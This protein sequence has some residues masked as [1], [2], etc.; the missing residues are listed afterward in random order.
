MNQ[1]ELLFFN[2]FPGLIPIY[3][4]LKTRLEATYPELRL[5]LSKTQISFY[6]R[7]MFAM[8]SLPRRLKGW[9]AEYLLVS[10]GLGYRKESPRIAQA[11][12]PYP[13]RWTHHVPVQSPQQ[14]DEQ[15]L[16]WLD[17]AYQF[18]AGKR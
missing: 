6:N 3:R 7:R 17:E 14:V 10:F 2:Q 9:P 1:D 5:K 13:N 16:Q 18:A 4:R 11:V 15:L 8:V 12:E